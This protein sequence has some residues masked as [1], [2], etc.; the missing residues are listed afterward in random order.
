M[1][2]I[3]FTV[4]INGWENRIE[5]DKLMY[6]ICYSYIIIVVTLFCNFFLAVVATSLLSRSMLLQFSFLLSSHFIHSFAF[7]V[8]QSFFHN[9]QCFFFLT[10]SLAPHILTPRAKYFP[11]KHIHTAWNVARQ[12]N[13]NNTCTDLQSVVRFLFPTSISSRLLCSLLTYLCVYRWFGIQSNTSQ[14]FNTH[15]RNID[16]FISTRELWLSCHILRVFILG[17]TLMKNKT[18]WNILKICVQRKV[19][20]SKPILALYGQCGEWKK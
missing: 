17:R 15:T 2:R 9:P 20:K 8:S 10:I 6:F 7:H 19:D 4:N 12:P 5:I 16:W 3:L 14:Y 11:N 18:T 1:V 13:N